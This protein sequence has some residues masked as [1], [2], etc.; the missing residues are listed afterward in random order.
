MWA[1][2]QHHPDVVKVL[3]E[4]GASV[5]AKSDVWAD[6]MAVP[7]HGLLEYNRSIPHGG[8]TA[9]LFAARVGDLDSARILVA[10]GAD[11]NDRDAWGITTTVLAAHSGFTEFVEFLLERG[12]DPNLAPAGFTA[13]HE[14]IMR[15]D[16]RL[17]TVL[18]NHG[19]DPN[20]AVGTWTPTRR[21][22][23]D[24]NFHPSLVGATPFWLAA[25]FD[26]PQVMRLLV[27]GGADPLVVH[28]GVY[29]VDGRGG[30]AFE[31][32][33]D[34]TNAVMAAVGMGRAQ[35]W[36]PIDPARREALTLEAV[37]LATELGGD[38]NAANIDGRTALDAAEDLKYESVVKFLNE[39]GARH[40]VRVD[41]DGSAGQRR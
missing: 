32:R 7:P 9:L 12:A 22:S 20:T 5:A 33:T 8:E 17:V 31:Q 39:K 10:A 15:R 30:K 35:A 23:K 37:R 40:G 14:A 4:H 26:E 41:S 19:A 18:L 21:D 25:R 29:S 3:V 1:V 34:L 24:W 2:A 16:E 6:V 36:V 27:K 38:I 11:V 28:K 13:L